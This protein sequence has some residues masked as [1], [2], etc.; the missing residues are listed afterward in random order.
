MNALLP[1]LEGAPM[2][3][4]V[5]HFP[6]ALWLVGTGLLLWSLRGDSK[7]WSFGVV[8]VHLGSAGAIVASVAGFIA[9]DNLGHDSPGHGMVHDHRN[10]ML[11]ATALGLVASAIAFRFR[12]D[13]TGGVRKGIIALMVVTCAVLTL[14][15]DRGANLV[16]RYGVG[17]LNETPPATDDGHSHGHDA[18]GH[19]TSD[20]DHGHGN[21]DHHASAEPMRPKPRPSAAPAAS[22]APPP[23]P[24]PAHHHEGDHS[25]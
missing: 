11:G 10:L 24:S 19:G 3:P 9:A 23:S 14:G 17:V 2:H 13:V 25:H 21:A 16:Y 5:V 15:A 20:S 4:M 1:G 8:L 6:I 7:L 18:H 12:K 22:S